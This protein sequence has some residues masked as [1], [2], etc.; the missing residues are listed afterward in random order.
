METES[1]GPTKE[2]VES[3]PVETPT[4]DDSRFELFKTKLQRAFQ[5]AHAQSLTVNR[6]MTTINDDPEVTSFSQPEVDAA[7]EK[8]MD[9]IQ[10]LLVPATAPNS[11]ETAKNWRKNKNCM[12]GGVGAKH[13]EIRFESMVGRAIDYTVVII[14]Q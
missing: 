4:I 1:T 8:M 3:V 12:D 10:L 2:S 7:L 13:V 5:S 9:A 11:L 6:I 14:G